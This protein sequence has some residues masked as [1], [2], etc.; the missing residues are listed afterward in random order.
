V[1]VEEEEEEE[2]EEE[3]EQ[4]RSRRRRRRRQTYALLMRPF[5]EGDVTSL[6]CL[7]HCILLPM[8][9]HPMREI[10]M[11]ISFRYQVEKREYEK[12][13]LLGSCRPGCGASRHRQRSGPC[14]TQRESSSPT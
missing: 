10:H 3:Q 9:S 5:Q 4:E 13:M 7:H 8:F 1:V 2:E 11:L 6:H 14:S 12:C